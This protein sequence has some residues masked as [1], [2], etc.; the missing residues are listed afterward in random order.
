[1]YLS[2]YNRPRPDRFSF[3]N[4]PGGRPAE[5]IKLLLYILLLLGPKCI[6][7]EVV[8]VA[9]HVNVYVYNS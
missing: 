3:R 5:F 9:I 1:M 2:I 6:L 4:E 8:P 7:Y